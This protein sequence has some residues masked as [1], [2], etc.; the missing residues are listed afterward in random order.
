MLR[1]RSSGFAL[2]AMLA[3]VLAVPLA[4]QRA[5][6]FEFGAFGR[7]TWFENASVNLV[8]TFGG[9]ALLGVFLHPIVALEVGAAYT[10]AKTV[11]PA[12]LDVKHVPLFGRLVVNVP[13]HERFTVL[14]GG[15]Y[16]RTNYIV[17]GPDLSADNG[18][19]G[20]LGFRAFLSG[21]LALRGHGLVDFVPSPKT[22]GWPAAGAATRY[23]HWGAELGLTYVFGKAPRDRDRDGVPDN[24][25]ACPD[26]PEGVQV[27][28]N[29]CPVDADRDGVADYQD[30]CASTPAGASVDPNG[31][32][33]DSDGDR[34]FDGLDQCPN[35]P[36]GASVDARGCPTDADG[37]NV[38]DGLD[39]CPNTPA[40]AP[41]DA[42]GCPTDADGDGVIDLNDRCP[43]TP[44][45]ARADTSGCPIDAD[46]DKVFD[47]LD[48]CPNTPAGRQVDANGCP[49]LFE[50][51]KPTLV[52]EGV[53]F[54]TGSADLTGDSRTVLDIV[55]ESLK[56]NPDVKVEVAG[57]TDI[58]G[59][60][61]TNRRLSQARAESV[62]DYLISKGLAADRL[63]ARGYG[64]DNPV[65]SNNT[66]AG[67]QENR[68]VELRKLN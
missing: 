68:R 58:T 18:L 21:G 54:A 45:G 7:Y 11:T 31:C 19:M 29:G 67:R 44:A 16:Q 55:A 57:H 56:G 60:A 14:L 52:L 35:T 65:A 6:S 41:V 4:A 27:E 46:G 33:R 30:R 64:P 1:R 2:G 32:P 28:A 59:S 37:D 9:S 51:D 25:D 13:L 5:G 10:P 42:R 36:A 24:R 8:D 23:R 50:P 39:Q 26:T 63:T 53:T 47:G 61:A 15:G 43:N 12:D 62:R 20:L 66:V 34:V 38:F 22:P 48:R 49:I 3:T 17:A 40:G